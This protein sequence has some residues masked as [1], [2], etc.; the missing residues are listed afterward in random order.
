[1][2]Y[3]AIDFGT[4]N[5]ALA[6]A[7]AGQ[8]AL[9]ELEPGFSTMPTAVFYSAGEVTRHYGRAAVA[10]Y[11]DGI[12]GRLMRSLKSILGSDLMEETT[13]IAAGRSVRYLDVVIG[14]LSRMRDVAQRQFG[15][16]LRRAVLGRP[17]YFVDDDP[18]RDARAQETLGRAARMAGF[19]SIDFEF[20]PIAAARDFE[21]RATHETVVLVA[22]IGGGTSDFSLVRV[23]PQ[24]RNAEDRRADILAN[25]GVHIAGTDF[26]R[27]V[28][29]AA[30]LPL[31]GYRSKTPE[32]RDVPASIYFDLATWHLIN[33]TYAHARVIEIRRMRPMYADG[34][35]HARL[36]GILRH[37]LGHQLAARAEQAKIDVAEHGSARIDLGAVE[38]RLTA[39]LDATRQHAALAENVERIV[40]A[41]RETVRRAQLPDDRVEAVYFTGGSTG[42]RSLAARIAAQFPGAR[43]VHGDRFT[44]VVSGLALTAQRRFG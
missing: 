43:A 35:M 12:D 16:T 33:T 28:N 41:A 36:L 21:S 39:A 27:S 11:V 42:L 3:C 22:D 2:S 23:G 13:E 9:A 20:E 19:E 4:S 34:R 40:A 17:V 5:S 44:S 31:A 14:Y 32:G 7:R 18:V 24:R 10:A 25:H 15:V 1:M 8:L 26:D 38:A 29:L 30:I 6:V 37:R